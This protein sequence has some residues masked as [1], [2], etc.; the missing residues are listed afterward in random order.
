MVRD[1]RLG[2]RRPNLRTSQRAPG[3]DLLRRPS[4]PE[5]CASPSSGSTTSIT[6][7]VILES[8]VY[9]PVSPAQVQEAARRLGGALTDAEL[10][11]AHARPSYSP[12]LRDLG[13]P[14]Y[15]SR[16]LPRPPDALDDALAELVGPSTRQTVR[17]SSERHAPRQRLD[18]GD[19]AR[20]PERFLYWFSDPA[21][22]TGAQTK[23]PRVPSPAEA[24]VLPNGDTVL[25]CRMTGEPP[26]VPA[27]VVRGGAERGRL[28][29][30]EC[31]SSCR[32]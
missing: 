20:L 16:H 31:P 6:D 19:L 8:S 1:W 30:A 29:G 2:P 23:L 9:R 13:Q 18:A 10:R 17:L 27:E 21:R 28:S 26:P 14:A 11:H 25:D 5:H 7:L 24:T 4:D 32:A 3:P 22:R 12:L 15:R